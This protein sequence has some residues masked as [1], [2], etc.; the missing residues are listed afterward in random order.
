MI[1]T[2]LDHLRELPVHQPDLDHPFG[3]EEVWAAIRK[4]SMG[5]AAGV[6]GILNSII[7]AAAD[8]VG[9]SE[10]A[11]HN[12]M[13][14]S[15]SLLFNFIFK[16]EVW[17]KRWGQGIIFPIYKDGSRLDPGNYRPI[18]LLSTLSKLFGSIIEN[19]L[20]D[21]SER[22]MAL[23][24]EQGGFRKGRGTPELIFV[25][26]EIILNRKAHGQPTIVTFIDARKAYDS[27]WREGNF[28]HLHDLGIR[29]KLWRQIQ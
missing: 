1:L 21:W 6:D 9:N 13:V 10:L 20:S 19:R 16:H 17:P 22:T 28:V 3:R 23:A 29:G 25:L 15:I 27:V 24:D 5:K 26:R 2:R 11:E 4:L 12:P 8:A 14:D 18:A 7:K